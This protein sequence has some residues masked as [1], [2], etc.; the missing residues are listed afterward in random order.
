[1]LELL[2]TS[3]M[4]LLV[5]KRPLAQRSKTWRDNPKLL[6]V[7]TRRC[8]LTLVLTAE[9]RPLSG[10]SLTVK[11][12]LLLKVLAQ[13]KRLKRDSDSLIASES[14]VVVMLK[15]LT[16]FSMISNKLHHYLPSLNK[17]LKVMPL[18]KILK[19]KLEMLTSS[20]TLLSNMSNLLINSLNSAKLPSPTLTPKRRALPMHSSGVE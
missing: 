9:E 20:M 8:S 5:P 13:L 11:S 16:N 10:K 7:I 17:F 19:A 15:D 1:M 4:L 14:T 6:S 2:T 18:R 3:T 12:M